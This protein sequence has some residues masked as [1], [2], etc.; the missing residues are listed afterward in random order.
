MNINISTTV[1]NN[2]TPISMIGS[3]LGKQFFQVEVRDCWPNFEAEKNAVQME[4][5]QKLILNRS[6]HR[7]CIKS[8]DILSIALGTDVTDN[9]V[10]QRWFCRCHSS[11]HKRY[12][13]LRRG[14]R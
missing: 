13:L 14:N 1:A 7:Y 6:P 2:R 8:K 12:D 9:P 3:N 4:N 10:V 5:N 11:G